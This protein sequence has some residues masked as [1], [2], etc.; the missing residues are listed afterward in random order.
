MDE[1][2]IAEQQRVADTFKSL[3]LIPVAIRVSDAVH[4]PQR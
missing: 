3:G 2:A 1:D 4:R